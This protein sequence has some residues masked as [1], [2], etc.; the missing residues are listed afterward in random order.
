MPKQTYKIEQF[1]G[2]LNT[3]ADPRDIAE[4]QSSDIVGI[5]VNNLGRLRNI[6]RV[7]EDSSTSNT[8]QLLDNKGLFVMDSDRK[9]SNNASSNELLIIV[10]DDSSN[11]FDI[12]DSGGWST[13]EISLATNNPVFYSADGILRIADGDLAATHNKWYGYISGGKFKNLNSASGTI[14]DWVSENQTIS[15]PTL[16]K[17]L[18]SNPEVGSD[19]NGVNSSASEYIGNV[20]DVSGDD[21][22]VPN[23]VNLRVGVQYSTNYPSAA[24]NYVTANSA[25]SDSTTIYPLLNDQTVTIA[26]QTSGSYDF[27]SVTR[28]IDNN[29]NED[30]SM[31]TGFYI[32]ET[33][34][35]DLDKVEIQLSDG[36]KNMVNVFSKSDIK[37][38]C[39]NLL[40]S[41]LTNV[42][43]GS[44]S[45][46]GLTAWTLKVYD[47]ITGSIGF[48]V[49][50]PVVISNP[51]LEGFQEGLYSFHYTF[52]YDDEKQESLPFGF[53]DV[54]SVNFS[55]VNVL[56]GSILFNFDT[57]INT[58]ADPSGSYS[59]SKR[60]V[61]SRL[62]Y[63]LEENDNFYLIGELDF[64]DK[65]FKW[66]PEGNELA[67]SISNTTN[68]SGNFLSKA[69][70]I[71]GISPLSA[72][73]I[74]TFKNIN[75]FDGQVES[76]NCRYKTAVIH[77]RRCYIGNIVKDSKTH[78]D[79]M[80]KSRINKFDTF[81]SGNGVVD[82]A[83]RDG[84]NIVKL[85]AF[86]DRI[87]QFKQK[88][89]YIINVAENVEFLEDVY[90]NKG[91]EF[92]Y[93]VTKTDYG[94]TWF[95]KFGVY[96]FNGKSVT[97]L[98]EKDN[99]KLIDESDWEAFITDGED[100]SSDDTDMSSAHIGYLPKRRQILI[101]N[102]NTNLF[103]YD[104]LLR[105][106]TKTGINHIDINDPGQMT[107]FALDSDQNLFYI[108][109]SSSQIET[110]D[111]S[112][113]YVFDYKYTTKDIDFGQPSVR[114]KI[115]KVYITYKSGGNTNVLVK[116]DTNGHTDYNLLFANGT[117]F[118]SNELV[119]DSGNANK[120]ITAELKPNTSSEANNVNSFALQIISEGGGAS[121]PSS[122]EI[123]DITIVYRIKNVK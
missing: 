68:T 30:Q 53:T 36:S 108:S 57:Y 81:P 67:Y 115:Y 47:N 56:G 16:G 92:P 43:R 51:G 117:N 15:S 112:P 99:I 88:S 9:V 85:E 123:N 86:A 113:T 27:V 18:I 37:P 79:R 13:A 32:T 14:N 50:G 105:S 106:W 72:N 87:L 59:F 54:D 103:I 49:S 82:V 41:S 120:W 24:S 19:S 21:V 78:P 114:K 42:A 48:S 80:M 12:K 76:I 8:I 35:N 7:N 62:Y 90:R 118:T 97:N 40:V 10:F 69:S 34:W 89:L 94:I 46:E 31:V 64:V 110:F 38:N 91:C 2:G 104:L 93:H 101:K 102:E 52:I 98:L 116:Y 121:V 22:A 55:K 100:G 73:I 3:N 75:G 6:G 95:N 119:Y 122:F 33:E 45:G 63:K 65:G 1:H 26:E 23:A 70:L 25:D 20:V 29:V 71:K 84:E 4:N 107:N 58:F 17:C 77:G 44:A 109:G 83:I 61:G 39:W 11:T 74:D 66:F 60:I 5:S 96:L 28:T 111:P